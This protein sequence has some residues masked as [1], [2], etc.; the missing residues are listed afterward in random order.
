MPARQGCIRAFG[1]LEEAKGCPSLDA[2][3]NEFNI[4]YVL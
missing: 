2:Q 1:A 3:L 4:L